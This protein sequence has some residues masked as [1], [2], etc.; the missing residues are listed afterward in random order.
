MTTKTTC[1]VFSG[2]VL[3]LCTISLV[4]SHQTHK[5]D[6][7]KYVD[8]EID[9][10]VK[11]LKQKKEIETKKDYVKL[12][13]GRLN[14]IQ[15]QYAQKTTSINVI[16]TKCASCHKD[17]QPLKDDL[18][19]QLSEGYKYRKASTERLNAGELPDGYYYPS[20]PVVP[21]A[22]A[23]PAYQFMYVPSFVYPFNDPRTPYYRRY[24]TIRR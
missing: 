21:T 22:L 24:Y 15:E 5:K 3:V 12:L 10:G 1:V 19:D 16:Q 6:I 4:Y 9:Y 20:Q 8:R 17:L 18:L 7:S 2:A 13:T 23:I 14:Q 11:I